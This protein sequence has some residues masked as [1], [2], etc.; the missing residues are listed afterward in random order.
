MRA[1]D[2]TARTGDRNAGG[3]KT[4]CRRASFLQLATRS[5]SVVRR[6]PARCRPVCGGRWA[7]PRGL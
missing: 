2:V 5:N 3:A 6:P 1:V 7:A 4:P